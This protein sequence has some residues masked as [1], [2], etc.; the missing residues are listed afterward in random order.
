MF[1]YTALDVAKHIINHVNEDS[2]VSNLKLQKLLY[3]V[4]GFFLILKGGPCFDGRIEAWD[5]GPVVPDVYFQFRGCGSCG[6]P[7]VDFADP[8]VEKDALLIDEVVDIFRKKSESA[9]VSL[10][11]GQ[12]PWKDAYSRSDA[13]KEI[14]NKAIRNYFKERYLKDA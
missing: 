7:S 13:H 11:H 9:L 10:V 1:V 6:I 8:I 12:D 5:F 4:Q 2:T 3:F 14:K